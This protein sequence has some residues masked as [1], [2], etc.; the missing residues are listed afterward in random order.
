MKKVPIRINLGKIKKLNSYK[1]MFRMDE[2]LRNMS[3]I[4][5]RCKNEIWLNQKR[6][7]KNKEFSYIVVCNSCYKE[8]LIN[9]LQ[10][11]ENDDNV[12]MLIDQK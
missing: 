12:I 2:K 5:K 6:I 8:Y 7:I 4:C 1:L 3:I 10:S 9:A 11:E